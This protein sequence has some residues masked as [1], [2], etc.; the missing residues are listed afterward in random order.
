MADMYARLRA[1]GVAY[2]EEKIEMFEI[3][4]KRGAIGQ[5]GLNQQNLQEDLLAP[6]MANKVLRGIKAGGKV[7]QA[8]QEA[9]EMNNRA[10]PAIAYFNKYILEGKTVAEAQQLAINN[11]SREQV[12]YAKENWPGI[13]SAHGF[14]QAFMFKKFGAVQAINYYDSL[15]R[16]FPRRHRQRR[17]RQG[18]A[19]PHRCRDAGAGDAR[20]L[21]RQ[22]AVGADPHA[23]LPAVRSWA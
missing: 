19:R 1:N 16:A 15:M 4:R 14:S 18:C 13:A 10:V 8:F 20:R 11:V 12:N 23:Q 5:A 7:F 2:A 9:A 6:G 21:L 3:M 22:P 17:G